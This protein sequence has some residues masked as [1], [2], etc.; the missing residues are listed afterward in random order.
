MNIL[1]IL[2]PVMVGPSSSHT[3]GAARIGMMARRLLGEGTPSRAEITL[4]GSFAATGQGHGTDRALIA[5]LL[6]MKP[7]DE[8]IAVSFDWATAAGMDFTF[9]RSKLSAE[10]PNTAHINLVSKSGKTLSVTASSLGGGRIVVT[11][12]NG[13]H[14][15]FSGDLPTLIV[16]NDDQP[17]HVGDVTQMLA[18]SGV[19]IA[20]MQLYRDHPGG[21]AVMLIETDKAVSQE[22]IEEMS[23]MDGINGVTFVGGDR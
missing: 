3:A 5:G 1:D 18:E 16:Q 8:R 2:G 17:G 21:S 22:V 9:L 19:N 10:H 15:S 11:E 12:M 4:Y 7:D 20:T 13:L 6:G 14:A 23:R